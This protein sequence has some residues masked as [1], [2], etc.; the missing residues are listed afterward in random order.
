MLIVNILN[1][2]MPASTGFLGKSQQV[3]DQSTFESVLHRRHF[4]ESG[5]PL[6]SWRSWQWGQTAYV[7]VTSSPSLP[8]RVGR[9]RPV[10]TTMLQ[11]SGGESRTATSMRLMRTG[12]L[13]TSRTPLPSSVSWTI[14]YHAPRRRT[15]ATLSRQRAHP[16]GVEGGGGGGM[17]G[18]N[19]AHPAKFRYAPDRYHH[20]T[21]NPT[22]LPEA[23]REAH[24]RL[25][26]G[27]PAVRAGAERHARRRARRHRRWLVDRGRASP[28]SSLHQE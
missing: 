6:K 23:R 13:R 10:R 5:L 24:P 16:R 9:S 28:R 3:S 22:R 7:V 18:A 2:L 4:S 11:W 15:S 17:K 19:V 1:I 20:P 25:R 27:P 14:G 12:F 21:P 8:P 26:S